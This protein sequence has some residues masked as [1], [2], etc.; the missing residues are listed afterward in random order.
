MSA[1]KLVSY[2]MNANSVTV[3]FDQNIP[4]TVIE[5]D[6]RYTS[7]KN[8]LIE[9]DEQA[10]YNAAFPASTIVQQM[11]EG[12]SEA[13]LPEDLVLKD[14][15]IY[16]NGQELDNVLVD[17][18]LELY[19]DGGDVR[20]L[21]RFLS[22]LMK[23]PSRTAVQELFLF[24]QVSQLPID[25]DGY[26][27]AYKRIRSDWKD[28][29]SGTLDNSIGSVVTMPR[30]E[31]DD[32]R[33]N[34]C[35]TGLHFCAYG[36]LNSYGVQSGGRIVVVK[37]DPADVVSIPSD[38]KNMK[39][40]CCRYEVIREIECESRSNTAMPTERIEG[41][42]MTT[43]TSD[44]RR[45]VQII[46][47]T[48]DHKEYYNSLSEAANATGLKPSEIRRVLRGDRKTTGGFA[49]QY[50]DEQSPTQ[51]VD[52]STLFESDPYRDYD[53]FDDDDDDEDDYRW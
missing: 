45:I 12:L 30:N 47:L 4:V 37:I 16:Y 44:N 35:S 21:G 13:D 27:Y 11:R 2:I 38:Y 42:I 8:A 51:V 41:S 26:F 48:G 14:N 24:L 49:W 20:P 5:T 43:G 33:E 18:I 6:P 1:P 31:V 9:K 17:R 22:R 32:Q 19:E 52:V 29:Y 10:A 15:S 3:L 53:A 36:Y 25:E 40:R 50:V 34:H 7:L 23:N 28:N 46:P 39:G